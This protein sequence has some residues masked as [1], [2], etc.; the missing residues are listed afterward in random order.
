MKRE[1]FD[2]LQKDL[3]SQFK[4]LVEQYCK[5][6]FDFVDDKRTS[7]FGSNAKTDSGE[8]FEDDE[9]L[10]MIIDELPIEEEENN[11]IIMHY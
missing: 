7:S 5:E 2:K 6:L 11:E 4:I 8:I 3:E 9:E 1:I 10:D